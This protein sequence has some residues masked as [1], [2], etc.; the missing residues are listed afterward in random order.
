MHPPG[1]KYFGFF[2]FRSIN[3]LPLTQ[4]NSHHSTSLMT[5]RTQDIYTKEKGKQKIIKSQCL[6]SLGHNNKI[7]ILLIELN[8]HK[9]PT[10]PSQS[11]HSVQHNKKDFLAVRRKKRNV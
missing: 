10:I 8:S 6:K 2:M 9:A 5:F 3:F 4:L 1:D 7:S 11:K